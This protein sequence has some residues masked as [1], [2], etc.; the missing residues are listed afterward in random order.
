[1]QIT[2]IGAAHEV[3]GS[4]TFLSCCGKNILIDCGMEQG[5]NDYE[6]VPLP[7]SAEKID[8]VF[9]TH[10]HIDHS[11]NLPLLYKEGFRG[12]IFATKATVKLCNIMLQDSAHI[13]EV[14]ADYEN[15]KG[16]RSNKPKVEPEYTVS[17]AKAVVDLME[18]HSYYETILVLDNQISIRFI[19]IGHLLGSA[20]IE[21]SL[22]EDGVK[23]T[24]TF[25]GDVGNHDQAL[26][27][28]PET[29]GDTDYL[30]IESTYG[31]RLHEPSDDGVEKLAKIIQ[32]TLDRGGNL[33]I[34]S[35]AVGRTQEILYFIRQIKKAGLV[36]GHGVFPVYVDS[37]LAN[38]A[39]KVFEDCDPDFL[40][41]ETRAIIARG[42]N[43]LT[44]EGLSTCISSEDSKALNDNKMPK[45]IISAAGMCDAG[46]IRHHLKYNLWREDSTILFVGYQSVGT[47]GRTIIDGAKSVKL[48]GEEIAVN[49]E[50]EAFHGISGHADK[51]GLLDW[52]QAIP[53]KPYQIFVNHGETESCE[54]FSACLQKEYGYKAFA[55]FSG[56][57]Y[58]LA[59]GDFV[60]ITKGVPFKKKV[61]NLNEGTAEPKKKKQFVDSYQNLIS[62]AQELLETA[63]NCSGL[64]RRR[65][66]K[67]TGQ[68]RY[69]NDKWKC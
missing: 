11:G 37:P 17:D 63:Y 58:D 66:K 55:P 25:S 54:A 61:K 47:L 40:D 52:V 46:R 20:C 13:K 65:L 2:F 34:P 35:F 67:F 49:A 16:I 14:D 51:K 64:D 33:I 30:V 38:E 50:I 8:Y 27:R 1:M 23:K 6:N 41:D 57:T 68:I 60:Q 7:V 62:T 43:P 21:I 4:C 22:N 32:K 39:T 69:L 19:D 18:G 56:T 28:D 24:I 48:F 45:V 53:H 3:T 42:E 26:I 12:K 44:F 29:I 10:A 59:A 5:V 9:L 31:D 36:K 15:R